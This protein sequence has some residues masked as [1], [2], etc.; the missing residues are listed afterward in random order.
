MSGP[1][2][3]APLDSKRPADRARFIQ[4]NRSLY[5]NDPFWVAPLDSEMHL[6]LGPENPFFSHAEIQLWVAHRDG[7]DCGRIAALLDR[8]HN[9]IHGEQTAFFGFFECDHD[10]NTA[11][12]LLTAAV[13]WA[14]CRGM[15][16][17]LGPMNPS[18]NDECGLLIDGFNDPPV[19][20][21]TYN[22]STYPA[23]VEAAGFSKAKD[24]LAFRIAVADAPARRL[25]RLREEMGR[26]NPGIQLHP[27]TRR[28]L[29]DDVPR[30][31]QIYNEAWERNWG[32]VPLTHGEI[33]FLVKRLQ[34]LLV[35]GLVW[36]AESAG[37][38]VGF[39]LAVPDFNVAL[40]PLRG[41]LLSLGVL[42]ALPFLV[43]WKRP[44]R[45]RLVALGVRKEFR[46]RGVEAA[47]L[48]GTLEASQRNGYLECEASWVLENNTPVRRL[49][50]LFG[51]KHYKTYR[52]YERAV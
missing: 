32:A 14:R 15:N 35:D 16:R 51:G 5:R 4:I 31:K 49:V 47:M 41:R 10:P 30:I 19:L 13:D 6:V 22:P 42:E 1:V 18:I 3:L 24:L 17:V 23:L 2:S 20:M 28:S 7:R 40:H 9:D 38:P 45:M 8:S 21:M 43:G 26:R 46:G 39:L 27:V 12:A 44:R 37:E 29:A 50:G 34:P 33:D 11:A 25:A 52:L 48:A 36:L